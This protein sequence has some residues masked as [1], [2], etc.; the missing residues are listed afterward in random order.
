MSIQEEIFKRAR[1]F[2]PAKGSHG[3]G[4][5]ETVMARARKIAAVTR[6]E[7]N[8]DP[9]AIAAI[10]FHD[11]G[12]IDGPRETHEETSATRAHH[13]LS[14]VFR[15]SELLYICTAIRQHRASF[16]GQRTSCL[17]E[18]LAAADRDVPSDAASIVHRCYRF[19]MEQG[20][21]VDEAIR[22]VLLH[23]KGKYGSGGYAYINAPALY[24]DYYFKE[25]EKGTST[26]D[27]LT[28][29]DVRNII[30]VT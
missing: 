2:Y 19:R 20:M 9:A 14:G 27:A 7:R 4:H 28:A 30:G 1:K 21:P 5:I 25:I 12:L 11:S 17:S 29:A 13:V 16:S 8:L 10:A 18:L 15:P 23:I 26:I 3:W 22:D 6:E 24:M